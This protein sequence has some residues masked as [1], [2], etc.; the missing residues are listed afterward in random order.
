MNIHND[1]PMTFQ[2]TYYKFIC[3]YSWNLET[4]LKNYVLNISLFKIQPI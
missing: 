1:I 3:K 2:Y 4:I